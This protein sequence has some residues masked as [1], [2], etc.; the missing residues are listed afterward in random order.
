M[1]LMSFHTAAPTH[2]EAA[3]RPRCCRPTTARAS[4]WSPACW[5]RCSSGWC[6]AGGAIA[7][8]LATGYVVPFDPEWFKLVALDLLDEAGVQFLLPRV[9]QR[10]ARADGRVEGVVFETKSGP[11]AIRAT[12]TIDCTGDGDVAVQ[13]GAPSEVGRADG[14]V[15]PMTLM[16]RMAEFQRAAFEAYVTRATRSSGAA[17]TA[18]GTWCARR[19]QAGEL[20]AAARGHPVL[21]HAARGRGEREQH[22][23]H[24]RARHR[25][26]GPE[27][28]R[29]GEPAPD[30]PDRGV[31]AP[32]R[33]G[34][35]DVLRGAERRA[36]RRA[37]DAARPRRL[38][39][40]RRR[41]ARARASSTTRSRA[42]P[43]RSTS[44]TRRA[45][46]RCSSACRRARPTTSR[47]AACCRSN[48]EGLIVAGRCISGTPR[49]ALVL[50]RD[51][52]RHGDRPGRRASAP[53][54]PRA[55]GS[56]CRATS[57]CADVQRELVRQGAS[58]RKGLVAEPTTTASSGAAV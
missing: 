32:L 24:A 34:L 56:S 19:P 55:R 43:I 23:R 20:R 2:G 25:R 54:S 41:R 53:R 6:S 33:A 37:R 18:C 1:P 28:R 58:L 48:V 51:A 57:R 22:A 46:A 5:R 15:Q 10:R 17:C 31:P 52:D 47:C 26:L 50:P 8:S 14:L 44:T 38:P 4:R 36:G 42:A 11:L 35:R 49:G 29:V 13:A 3:A 27:L 45:A 12:V 7:P 39:A 9:R 40:H 21:R 30:A 16:F